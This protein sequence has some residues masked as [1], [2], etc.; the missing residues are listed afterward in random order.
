[1][2]VRKGSDGDGYGRGL[3]G[4]NWVGEGEEMIRVFAPGDSLDK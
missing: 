2:R 4:V 1:M 3:E